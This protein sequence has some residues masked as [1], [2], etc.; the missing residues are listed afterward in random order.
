MQKT[1]IAR[2]EG[3][4]LTIK[5]P[6]EIQVRFRRSVYQTSSEKIQKAL[7]S[8]GMFKK[9]W[10]TLLQAGKVGE[11]DSPQVQEIKRKA[12]RPP[13]VKRGVQISTDVPD[14]AR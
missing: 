6:E 3:L 2:Y 1:Y 13:T 10:I 4:D 5:E 12:G 9:G 11:P 7:E 14:K 8:S